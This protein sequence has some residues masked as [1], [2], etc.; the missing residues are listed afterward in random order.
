MEGNT[1]AAA[2]ALRVA[3]N[4]VEAVIRNLLA[5]LLPLI[6]L[7]F[8]ASGIRNGSEWLVGHGAP[9][10]ALAF[11]LVCGLGFLALVLIVKPEHVRESG[12]HIRPGFLFG[13][14]AAIAFVW[15][16]IF[17][18]ISYV[19][20]E[21][22]WIEYALSGA[23]ANALP[24]LCDAYLWYFLDLIPGLHIN[25]ALGWPPDVALTGGWRGVILT[26]FRIV[27]V[28]QVFTLARRLIE[29]GKVDAGKRA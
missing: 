2:V 13:L 6:A 26:V 10:F 8:V 25:E 12:G 5:V 19:L 11:V 3:K 24:D 16:Y 14:V 17:G 18:A 20:L 7:A 1:S 15:I 9:A 23:R 21:L 22:G 28:Y 29:A 27:I 4:A